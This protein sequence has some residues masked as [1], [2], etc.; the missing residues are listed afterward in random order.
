MGLITLENGLSGRYALYRPKSSRAA[1]GV[2]GLRS[3]GVGLEESQF[4]HQ[5]TPLSCRHVV[6]GG[7]HLG[8]T[9]G[10]R[11][12]ITSRYSITVFPMHP[13]NRAQASN[14]ATYILGTP[15]LTR[16]H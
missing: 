3:V 16:R 6:R 9:R 12:A 14:R 1:T 2:K 4:Q 10:A 11:P 13:S 8:R 15:V 5:E 7:G